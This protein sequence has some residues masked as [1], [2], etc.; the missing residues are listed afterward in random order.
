MAYNDKIYGW[1]RVETGPIVR[2]YTIQ[3]YSEA[4]RVAGSTVF[5]NVIEV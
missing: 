1:R 4:G 5:Q 3:H 2:V